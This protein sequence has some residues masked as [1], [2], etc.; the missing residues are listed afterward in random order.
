MNNALKLFQ[1]IAVLNRNGRE[2]AGKPLPA[3]RF[4]TSEHLVPA[5]SAEELVAG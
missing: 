1:Q 4:P 2:L 3:G 5:L